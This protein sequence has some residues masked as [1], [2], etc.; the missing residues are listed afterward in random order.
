MANPKT[1]GVNLLWL[2]PGVVGGSEEYTVRLLRSADDINQGCSPEKRLSFRL[3]LTP[4]LL[5][6]YPDLQDRFY[7]NVAPGMDRFSMGQ[8]GLRIGLEH[9]WLTAQSRCDS[10]LHHAGGTVPL[11]R[12]TT[13]VVT[14]HD[15]QPLEYPE[16]FS[17]VKRLW[18]GSM[19]PKAITAA[20]T[21][22]C[23][24]QF[25]AD[26]IVELLGVSP[27]KTVVVSQGYQAMESTEASSASSS[28]KRFGQFL[29]YP[30]IM[31]KHKRHV[32]IVRALDHLRDRL[33]DLN[34]VFTGRRGPEFETVSRLVDTLGLGDRIHFLDRIPAAELDSLYRTAAATVIPSSYEGFGNPA[35]EAMAR[36]CPV[37]VADAA[38]L[39]EVV[40]EHA[41]KVPVGDVSGWA[42]VIEEVVSNPKKAERLAEAG[43]ERAASYDWATAGSTLLQVYRDALRPY[44]R[45]QQ[46]DV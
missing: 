13:T 6:A 45:N 40:G 3:Y 20:R 37:I 44:R 1:V 36:G 39:P 8:K 16:N 2:N 5:V 22:I 31:Y 23:P 29:L 7:C 41:E 28:T 14:V 4:E 46:E 18:L 19:I 17:A 9:S 30:A 35:L 32:D 25:T 42:D 38:A 34:V 43:L 24:S 21:V 15:L 12:S 26:R 11:V 27:E 10:L 33:G